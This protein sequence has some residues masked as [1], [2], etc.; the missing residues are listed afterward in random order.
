MTRRLAALWPFSIEA[1][2]IRAYTVALGRHGATPQGVFWNSAKSQNARFAALLAMIRAQRADA[3]GGDRPP[4]IADIGCGYG[5]L[6]EYM[7]GRGEFADWGYSGF[8]IN[9][10]MIRSCRQRFPAA[11]AGFKIGATPTSQ[12]DYALFSGTFNLCMIDDAAR[13]QRYILDQLA[14]GRPHCRRGMVLNL[15]CRRQMTIINNIFYA[16]REAI[17]LEMR[18]RFGDIQ[19]ADTPGLKHDVTL[20]IPA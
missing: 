5:A 4:T 1:G 19:V 17:L 8:D 2:V 6:Y 3:G 7:Q 20:F 18:R 11:Q 13:W 10:A 16:D 15:L 9:A 12:V 14:G